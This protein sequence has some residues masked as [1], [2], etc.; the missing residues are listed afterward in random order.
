M[1]EAFGGR[2]L[3]RRGSH[4]R[5]GWICEEGAGRR[6]IEMPVFDLRG[7]NKESEL[8]S[9]GSFGLGRYRRQR[10]ILWNICPT[11]TYERSFTLKVTSLLNKF[12]E[13]IT[14][15]TLNI[16]NRLDLL[17]R[18]YLRVQGALKLFDDS[19]FVLAE[20]SKSIR[21]TGLGVAQLHW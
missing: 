10:T 2:L 3:S 18:P 6:G 8:G 15:V 7:I 21:G 13:T 11:Q 1:V 5:A 16:K 9:S 4:G 20:L 12:N 14:L 17:C 19:L